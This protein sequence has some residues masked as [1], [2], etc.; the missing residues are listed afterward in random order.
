MANRLDRESATSYVITVTASDGNSSNSQRFTILIGTPGALVPVITWPTPTAIVY[1][2][3][4][5]GSQLNATADV[6]GVF[7]YTP[8]NNSLLTVGSQTLNVVFTPTDL[9]NYTTANSSVSLTV[10]PKILSVIAA[11]AT[12]VLGAVNPT[13]TGAITGVV[14]GDAITAT[15]ATSATVTTPVG[16]YGPLTPEAITPSLLDPNNRLSNYTMSTTK[17]TL[18]VASGSAVV[19]DGGNGGGGGGGGCGLGSSLAALAI[20]LMLGL[21]FSSTRSRLILK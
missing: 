15:Y 20:L 3:L 6:A 17:G 10:I 13:F 1:G 18:T 2:T 7:T 21:R 14:A 19:V 11:D 9:S 5:S 12:R 16:V 8:A 4:L